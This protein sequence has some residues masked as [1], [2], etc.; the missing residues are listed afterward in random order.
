MDVYGETETRI[1]GNRIAHIGPRTA[2]NQ[3][4]GIYTGS[5]S[6]YIANN[7][8]SDISGYGIHL[9]RAGG[10]STVINNDVRVT[11]Y[12]GIVV[13]AEAGQTTDYVLVANNIV[14]QSTYYGIREYADSGGTLGSHNRYTH[15]D[16]LGSGSGDYYLPSGATPQQAYSVDPQYVNWISDGSGDYHLQPSS[17]LI[18]AGTSQG[19]PS[20]DFDG[21]SRQGNYNVGAY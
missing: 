15:N 17:P 16:V 6:A 18:G 19:A 13:G 9:W 4:Q 21:N 12:G 10:N 14:R 3:M 11:R 20:T 5:T 7:I 8:L 2:C 1:T